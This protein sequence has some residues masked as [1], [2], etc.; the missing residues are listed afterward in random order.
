M[1]TGHYF[2]WIPQNPGCWKVVFPNVIDFASNLRSDN[3]NY[4]YW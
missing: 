3:D 1:E 4:K 2:V